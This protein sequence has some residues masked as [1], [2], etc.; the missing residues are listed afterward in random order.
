M[1]TS[2]ALF[3]EYEVGVVGVAFA[4]PK[5][6]SFWENLCLVS[7]AAAAA[8]SLA[9]AKGRARRDLVWSPAE[10]EAKKAKY[11]KGQYKTFFFQSKIRT[12][13]VCYFS[14]SMDTLVFYLNVFTI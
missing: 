11:C 2:A 6:V 7:A 1:S 12:V 10:R 13:L 4:L 14:L 3:L 5:T 8:A 9:W